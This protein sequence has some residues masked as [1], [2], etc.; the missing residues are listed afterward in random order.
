MQEHRE[1]KNLPN[2]QE[3]NEQTTGTQYVTE[4]TSEE[5]P[6]NAILNN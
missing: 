3:L 2:T 5:Q 6:S 4:S 1:W